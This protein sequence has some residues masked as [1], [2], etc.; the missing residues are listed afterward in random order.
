MGYGTIFKVNTDGTGFK[1]L[2]SFTNGSDGAYPVAGLVLSGSTLFGTASAGGGEDGFF[3]YGTVFKI[4]TDGT[5]FTNVYNFT[6]YNEGNYKVD[7][8]YPATDLLLSGNVL[9]GTTKGGGDF[10]YGN[11]FKVNTD[12]SGFTNLYSIN[13]DENDGAYPIANLV[14]SSNTLYGTTSEGGFAGFGTIFKVSTDGTGFMVLYDFSNTPAGGYPQAGLVMS[15]NTLYGTTEIGGASGYG[16]IFKVNTD[17]SNFTNLYGFTNG[18]DGA[19]VESGLVL[20]NNTLYGTTAGGEGSSGYGTVF[21]VNTNG[22]G[23][24]NLYNFTL[25]SPT[26]TN[27]DGALPDATLILCG[28]TLYGTTAAGGVYGNGT[29]FAVS[30]GPIPLNIQPS[31]GGNAVVLTWGNPAF[32][33][34]AAPTVTGTYINVP[35]AASSYTNVISGSQQFF[36]LQAN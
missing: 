25:L 32:S 15:G 18:S 28:N 3:G 13:F 4:N 1:S 33:L 10:G 30:L 6:N 21:K 23:F 27:S 36:R 11:V 35:G 16:T 7:G 5:G 14:L 19:F 8:D 31:S 2:Y 29:V 17:G 26:Y 20:S 9:Y 12:G 34:Q 24:T 22:N